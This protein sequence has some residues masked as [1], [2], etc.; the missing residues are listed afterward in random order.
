MARVHDVSFPEGST[1]HIVV[2]FVTGVE[3]GVARS[4][5]AID[6]TVDLRLAGCGVR[7]LYTF[8]K[9]F[10]CMHDADVSAH[11]GH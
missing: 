2:I 3:L 5:S 11:S 7:K 6:L 4:A 9:R 10:P 1:S 8:E